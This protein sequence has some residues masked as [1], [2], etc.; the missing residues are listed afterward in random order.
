MVF[1]TD[2]YERE[3]GY[4]LICS[5][6]NALNNIIIL[7]SYPDISEYS[8]IEQ[9]IKGVFN[10]KPEMFSEKTVMLLLLVGDKR[11]NFLITF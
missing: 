9:F 11:I 3:L 6:Q 4:A 1:L 5:A 7:P 2:L 8:L 10:V